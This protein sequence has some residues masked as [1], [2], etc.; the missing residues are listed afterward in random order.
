MCDLYMQDRDLSCSESILP[1]VGCPP[2]HWG[3]GRCDPLCG[4]SV[5][6]YDGGD[7]P[8]GLDMVGCEYEAQDGK[9]APGGIPCWDVIDKSI[10]IEAAQCSWQAVQDPCTGTA[11]DTDSYPSCAEEFEHELSHIA[12][13]DKSAACPPGCNYNG[14]GV[15]LDDP[16]G[17][18]YNSRCDIQFNTSACGFDNG[19]YSIHLRH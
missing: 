19:K 18:F 17:F 6:N 1:L 11:T 4:T 8:A 16:V 3:D 5:C 10:C 14:Y 13:P 9:Y 12:T 7:C 15:C 2:T